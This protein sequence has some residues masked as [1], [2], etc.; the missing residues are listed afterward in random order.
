VHALKEDPV[1][2][3]LLYVGTENGLYVSFDDGGRWQPLQN[4]LPHAPVYGIA[5]Q[6]RFHDIVV[7]TYG[8]GFWILDDVTPLRTLS[9]EAA[10]RDAWLFPPRAAYRLRGVAGPYEVG[11]DPVVGTNPPYGAS[12]TWWRRTAPD[13]T[14]PDSQAIA[15]F[16]AGGRLVR[17]MKQVPKAGMN[18]LWWDL[19]TEP[20]T[21][22]RLRT[23]PQYAPWLAVKPEGSPAP[24]IGRFST[25]VPPG[26]YTVRLTVGAQTLEQALDV[27]QDPN[28]R[29]SAE[30]LRAQGAFVADVVADLDSTVA[31]INRLEVL[32]GQLVALRAT[33]SGDSLAAD[34]RAAADT[35]DRALLAV[36]E[37]LFQ[38]RV[39]GRGQDQLR[40]PMRLAEQLI[41]LAQGA[42]GSDFGPTV[43]QREVQQ[44]LAGQVRE[45]R[46][47]LDRVMAGE[48]AAF[49]RFVRAREL[50]NLIF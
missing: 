20:T 6:E 15:V 41:Y 28:T 22:A 36:E 4:N 31:M 21:E 40:W 25:L 24:G 38:M 13:S 1:R 7:A 23:S 9:A 47:R 49:R 48:V 37:P 19:Q 39:T 18:R 12:L 11:D 16:D 43:P 5:V 35:L 33:L 32:R 17:T 2:R 34:V 14:R 30:E 42:T 29:A 50:P 44:L 3:G 45:A 10:A 27:L 8:R 26:R 46:E